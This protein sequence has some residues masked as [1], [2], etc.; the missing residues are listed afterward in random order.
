ML[1]WLVCVI[2]C[3]M[4]KAALEANSIIALNCYRQALEE[5]SFLSRVTSGFCETASQ[6]GQEAESLDVDGAKCLDGKWDKMVRANEVIIII[7]I[8]III[9]LSPW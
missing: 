8:I 2:V 1:E 7:I 9:I 3:R 5:K 4:K 6:V